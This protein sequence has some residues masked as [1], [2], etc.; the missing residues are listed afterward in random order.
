M[1]TRVVGFCSTSGRLRTQLGWARGTGLHAAG[2][3]G[4]HQP[5]GLLA[6]WHAG[7]WAILKAQSGGRPSAARHAAHLLGALRLLGTLRPLTAWSWP[8]GGAACP[9]PGTP[10]A[11][12]RPRRGTG[13][14]PAC[15]QA[16]RVRAQLPVGGEQVGLH[17][18]GRQQQLDGT[19]CREGTEPNQWQRQCSAARRGVVHCVQARLAVRRRAEREET[20]VLRG[21]V[22]GSGRVWCGRRAASWQQRGAAAAPNGARRA[23]RG[24]QAVGRGLTCLGTTLQSIR[25]P[26]LHRRGA[27]WTAPPAGLLGAGD[28]CARRTAGSA[29]NKQARSGSQSIAAKSGAH[30]PT[31]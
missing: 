31:G 18:H 25:V 28:C 12:G 16:A 26:N 22:A 23:G 24:M 10:G 5:G 13:P 2:R 27:A 20:N 15:S 17:L 21:R 19:Q 3:A 30:K 9:G 7:W 4:A 11:A 6:G 14:A 8:C 1:K 29:A